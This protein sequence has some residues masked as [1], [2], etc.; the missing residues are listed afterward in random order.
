MTEWMVPVAFMGGLCFGYA[1]GFVYSYDALQRKKK[2]DADTSNLPP[3]R[4]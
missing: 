4:W 1:I 3:S 2:L